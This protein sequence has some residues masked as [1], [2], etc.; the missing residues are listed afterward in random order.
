M[1]STPTTTQLRQTRQEIA[2]SE[3]EVARLR[4]MIRRAGDCELSRE[5]AASKLAA[6][7]AL[8]SMLR[9]LRRRI[10]RS[11]DVVAGPSAHLSLR[12]FQRR[13]QGQTTMAT[14]RGPAPRR[15]RRVSSSARP[16]QPSTRERQ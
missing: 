3:A 7:M 5:P 12:L 1:T 4:R 15:P 16:T 6:T 11:A 13:I 10:E 2:I 14:S 9:L 8:L